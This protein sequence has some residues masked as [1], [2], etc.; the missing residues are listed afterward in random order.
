VGTADEAWRPGRS[1]VRFIDRRF[2]RLATTSTS[3]V[4]GRANRPGIRSRTRELV[5]QRF[6]DSPSTLLA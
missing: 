4:P 2:G 1:I 3:P 5:R 6:G